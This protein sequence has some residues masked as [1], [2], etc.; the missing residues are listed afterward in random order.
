VGDNV[1]VKDPQQQ[2]RGRSVT[3]HMDDDRILVEG[4]EQGR[5]ETVFQNAPSHP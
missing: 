1:V 2:T 4:E 5:T 3:L